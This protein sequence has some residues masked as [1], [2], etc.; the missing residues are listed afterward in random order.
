ME[1]HG[2]ADPNADEDGK[3]DDD[4]EPVAHLPPASRRRVAA[5]PREDEYGDGSDRDDPDPG[6]LVGEL[7]EEHAAAPQLKLGDE[8]DANDADAAQRQCEKRGEPNGSP[9]FVGSFHGTQRRSQRFS[10]TQ[11]VPH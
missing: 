3:R 4:R 10:H 8:P 9:R 2:R 7:L 6:A 11:M 1:D 5:S